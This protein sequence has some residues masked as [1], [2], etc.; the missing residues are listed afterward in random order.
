MLPTPKTTTITLLTLTNY[1]YPILPTPLLSNT[2]GG[3]LSVYI[4]AT[5]EGE[6]LSQNIKNIENTILS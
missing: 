1:S 4:P 5:K 2:L 3:I 6:I